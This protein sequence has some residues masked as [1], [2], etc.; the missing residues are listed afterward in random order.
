M[1]Y[2]VRAQYSTKHVIKTHIFLNPAS[3]TVYRGL[4]GKADLFGT[5]VH[6]NHNYDIF[7]LNLAVLVLH[8]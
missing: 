5:T 8:T 2:S 4:F 7:F 6:L 1:S 3:Q